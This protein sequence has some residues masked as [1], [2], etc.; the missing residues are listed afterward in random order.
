ME[1]ESGASFHLRSYRSPFLFAGLCLRLC[2]HARP[3][4]RAHQRLERGDDHAFDRPQDRELNPQSRQPPFGA[5]EALFDVR[6]LGLAR[7]LGDP[8]FHLFQEKRR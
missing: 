1:V 8:V 4:G 5:D 2:A 7:R 6:E 3:R